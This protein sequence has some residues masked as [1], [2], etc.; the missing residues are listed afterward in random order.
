MIRSAPSSLLFLN[1]TRVLKRKAYVSK[2]ERRKGTK[3]KKIKKREVESWE[4]EA[5]SFQG[6]REKGLRNEL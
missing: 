1:S 5:E 2:N 3:R 4:P 6:K